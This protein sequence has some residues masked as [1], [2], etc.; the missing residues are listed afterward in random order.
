MSRKAKVVGKALVTTECLGLA[1]LPVIT[2]SSASSQREC[3][4]QSGK[5][6][7]GDMDENAVAKVEPIKQYWTPQ[8][9]TYN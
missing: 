4:E 7:T 6:S 8:S 1:L 5:N 9:I 3:A 2:Y